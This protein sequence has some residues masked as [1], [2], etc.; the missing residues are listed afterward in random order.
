VG[1]RKP[2]SETKADYWK[3]A[4]PPTEAEH[5]TAPAK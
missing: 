5:A 3:A 4:E 1:A 2:A